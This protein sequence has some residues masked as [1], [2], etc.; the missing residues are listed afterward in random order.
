MT[1]AP[2]ILPPPT[3]GATLRGLR[4]APG[5]P[6]LPRLGDVVTAAPAILRGLDLPGPATVP[7][8]KIGTGG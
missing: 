4:L 2:A 1:A 8:K 5:A 7:A 6:T 3:P